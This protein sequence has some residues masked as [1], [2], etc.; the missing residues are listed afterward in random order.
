MLTGRVP[1]AEITLARVC[2]AARFRLR[3]F[4]AGMFVRAHRQAGR[5]REQ[6]SECVRLDSKMPQAYLKLVNLYLRQNRREDAITQLQAFLK[7]FP[8]AAAAPKAQR[9]ADET[10]D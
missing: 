3:E 8:D 4:S 5:G 6:P 7:G 10:A 1:E 9:N 2:S